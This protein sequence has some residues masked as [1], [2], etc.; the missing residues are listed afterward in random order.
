MFTSPCFY[1][2]MLREALRLNSPRRIL[3]VGA[4]IVRLSVDLVKA[5]NEGDELFI[6]DINQ[7]TLVQVQT[8]LVT[9]PKYHE[10]NSSI[11]FLPRILWEIDKPHYFDAVILSGSLTVLTDNGLVQIMETCRNL[12][13]P[14]GSVSCFSLFG[15][16]EAHR[17]FKEQFRNNC[18]GVLERYIKTF[19]LYD[20][21]TLYECTPV[22]VHHLRFTPASIKD[23]PAVHA[24]DGRESISLGPVRI[25]RDVWKFALPL[26]GASWGL[27]KFGQKYWYVP[28]ALLAGVGAFLRDPE[29]EIKADNNTVLSAC[30]GEVLDVSEVEDPYLGSGRWLRIATFLSIF[31][32]H[33]NR[34][35]VSG[36]VIAQFDAEGGYANAKLPKANHNYSTY[37]VLQTE[38]GPVVVAQRVGLIARRIYNW[39]K[40]GEIL[41]QGDRF[42]LI[43]MGSRTDVYLPAGAC[44]P[45][46]SKGDRLEA[47]ITAIAEYLASPA[48]K[49]ALSDVP[50]PAETEKEA[51]PE[52]PSLPAAADSPEEKAAEVPSAEEVKP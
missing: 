20:D 43:R 23:I 28:L 39:V 9:E 19:S 40:R 18:S 24:L 21:C 45:L 42:G 11:T 29:R 33:I 52:A 26:L 17:L 15:T 38:R 30:D 8:A 22:T 44:R 1:S 36:K 12:L 25:A 13:K 32:T 49:T 7:D 46:V 35:P 4:S 14:G 27:K 37:T 34:A 51:V 10:F 31:D 6:T 2:S 5:L 41:A 50:V 48:A 3:L 16:S 47:G